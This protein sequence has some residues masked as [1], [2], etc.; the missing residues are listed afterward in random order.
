MPPVCWAVLCC[1]AL[2]ADYQATFQTAVT[3]RSISH[4]PA[5]LPPA[6]QQRTLRVA[7]RL[8]VGN[9]TAGLAA[10]ATSSAGAASKAIIQLL[11]ASAFSNASWALNTTGPAL[12]AALNALYAWGQA[13]SAPSASGLNAS[14][15]ALLGGLPVECAGPSVFNASLLAGSYAETTDCRVPDYLPAGSYNVWVCLGPYGCGFSGWEGRTLAV[16][17]SVSSMAP[18]T[19]SMAG[20]TQVTITG[21]GFSEGLA[22]AALGVALG[23][24]PCTPLSVTRTTLTCVTGPALGAASIASSSALP[25]ADISAPLSV[26]PSAGASLSSV[27]GAPAFT[28]SRLLTPWVGS[29][30]LSRGST[31][32]GTLLAFTV[33]GFE[34]VPTS[35]ISVWLALPPTYGSGL[36]SNASLPTRLLCENVTLSGTVLTCLT[37]TARPATGLPKAQGPLQLVVAVEGAGV[38]AG[39]AL[40]Y[41]YVDLWSRRSTWGGGPPPSEDSLVLIPAG[42]AAARCTV[43]DCTTSEPRGRAHWAA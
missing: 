14:S 8:A 34:S 15:L 36:S 3:P 22:L 43:L 38:A 39:P 42:E 37:P 33:S 13:Y 41:E 7:W 30:S 1:A 20:G 27:A 28:Y 35:A 11:P 6:G 9:S 21:S 24:R 23:G 4:S 29:C 5:T 25:S 32:G 31:E 26:A 10:A 40:T 19:G 16:P 17:L 18:L 2:Q 12:T